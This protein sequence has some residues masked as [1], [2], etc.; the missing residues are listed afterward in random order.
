MYD[1]QDLSIFTVYLNTDIPQ[2]NYRTILR[3]TKLTVQV[4]RRQGSSFEGRCILF[5]VLPVLTASV[6][7]SPGHH[8][9]AL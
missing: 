3:K 5:Q 9:Y 1:N 7:F 8:T 6:C 4:R 2:V